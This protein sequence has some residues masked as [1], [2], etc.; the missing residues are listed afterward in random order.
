MPRKKRG[1][2]QPNNFDDENPSDLENE[3]DGG[4][5]VEFVAKQ[6]E[7]PEDYEYDDDIAHAVDCTMG[8]DCTCRE[9]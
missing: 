9:E 4:D 1:A 6:V 2:K 8:S 3:D 5:W 7:S